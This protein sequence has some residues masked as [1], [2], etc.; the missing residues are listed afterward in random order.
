[1]VGRRGDRAADL[2]PEDLDRAA[3]GRGGRHR[4]DRGARGAAGGP[5]VNRASGL[6]SVTGAES[7]P[8]SDQQR[9]KNRTSG[10]FL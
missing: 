3:L 5:M 9:L 6:M 10:L 1:V 8:A 2:G 7:H 4:V